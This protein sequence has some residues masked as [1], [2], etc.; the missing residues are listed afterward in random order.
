MDA[1][2]FLMSVG[3][4]ARVGLLKQHGH[5]SAELQKRGAYQPR[6][7]IWALPTADKDLLTALVNNG[8]LTCASAAVR[9]G[10]WLKDRPTQIHVA[11]KHNRGRGFVR[12]GG[13]RVGSEALMPVASV[14]DTVLH[15]LNCLPDV[16]AIAVAQSAMRNLGV[17]R[18]V[19][20]GELRANYFGNA[21]RRLRMADG[22]SESVPEIS[23]RL[24][25]EAEGLPF[26]RQVRISGVGRVDT[27]IDGWLIVEVNGYQFH[28]S[29]AAWRNDMNRLNAAQA[30]GFQV[31]SFAPEQ[32]WNSADDVMAQIRWFLAQGRPYGRR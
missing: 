9:Y 32:I 14:E 12:H 22:L 1:V 27:L 16:D 13:L 24:L 5:T 2:E 29:R 25:F 15:A 8:H 4:V 3:G 10:L 20:E 31:L 11:T 7:G 30:R 6:H 19:L 17:P 26:E 28:S 18:E 23:A 21:R